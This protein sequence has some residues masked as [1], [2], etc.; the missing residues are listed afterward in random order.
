MVWS[1]DE[2][3]PTLGMVA[4]TV[5][6]AVMT[7]FVKKAMDE[8][9]SELVIIT[10]RQL[11]AAI[12]LS[13]IAFLKERKQRPKL[14]MEISI[15]IFLSA[16][17]GATLPQYLF[18]LGM[19]Y[20]TATFASTFSNLNP[21][22]TFLVALLLRME[23]VN[24]KSKPG[25]AK[26]IGAL[27]SLIGAMVLTLYKGVPLTHKTTH[28][29]SPLQTTKMGP[30]SCTNKWIFGSIALLANALSF[31]FWILLQSKVT[32]KYPVVYSGTALM[33]FLSFLQVAGLSVAVERST[34]VWLPKD[35]LQIMTVIYAGVASSGIGFVLMTW[36]VQK[37]GPVFTSSFLPLIQVFVALIDFA[38]L[39][40]PL[41]FGSVLG[42]LLLIIGLYVLLWG[43][44]KEASISS[45]KLP[46]INQQQQENK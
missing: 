16:I 12:F 24:I 15:Y 34:S 44:R 42:S 26:V 2:W 33:S 14:T 46:E 41:F 7:G 37:R 21:V 39:H 6:Y 10:L 25:L 18:F 3:K 30:N 35:K 38:V 45:V 19:K 5:I 40:E 1:I 4:F 8:G 23:S 36:A 13:P 11:I 28:P 20:T 9:M 32:K 31:S 22:I 43:K 27:L 29:T 17:L